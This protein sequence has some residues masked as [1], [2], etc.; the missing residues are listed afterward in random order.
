MSSIS[1]ENLAE[2]IAKAA[3]DYSDDVKKAIEEEI[4]STADKI[5]EEV[6]ILAKTPRQNYKKGFAKRKIKKLGKVE[7]TIYNKDYPHLVHLL[8]KGHIVKNQY[9][10]YDKRTKKNEHMAP[11]FE[12]YKEPFENKIEEII[13][14]G[15]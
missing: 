5:L 8:E 10:T 11:A 6:V 1:I 14:N 4:D 2:E 12:K 13:K 3:K 7:A 15:G 9:G